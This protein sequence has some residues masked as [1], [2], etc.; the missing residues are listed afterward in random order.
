M[1]GQSAQ[2]SGRRKVDNE[3]NE[4]ICIHYAELAV[5]QDIMKYVDDWRK[6]YDERIVQQ[7]DNLQTDKE[8]SRNVVLLLLQRG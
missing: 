4:K 6:H 8:T 1:F 5:N 3:L 2:G 7:L